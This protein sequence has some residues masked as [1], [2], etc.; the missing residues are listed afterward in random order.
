M[1]YNA[2]PK[3]TG[4]A[5]TVGYVVAANHFETDG[6][7]AHSSATRDVVNAKLTFAAESTRVTVIGSRSTSPNRRI[8][9]IDAA[10]VDADPRQADPV[11]VPSIRARP[12]INCRVGSQSSARLRTDFRV[13]GYG[14]NRQIG[15][16]RAVRR[17]T[18]SSGGGE[19]RL[20]LAVSAHAIS[21]AAIGRARRGSSP[22]APTPTDVS[23]GKASSTTTATRARA[24]R[25]RH[26]C[27]RRR[28]AQLEWNALPALSLTL[29]VR[30]SQVRYESVDHYIV[31]PN[32]DDSGT[33]T[34]YNTSPIAAAVWHAA[35]NL[36]VYVSY[37]QGF[38]TPTFAELAYR[39]VG[40]GLNL[41]LDPATSTSVEL[42]LKWLPSPR[43]RVN[44]AVFAAET[45]QEIVIDTATGGRTTYRNAGKTRR[46]GFEAV[47]DADL[48]S[49]FA[50]HANYSWLKAEFVDSFF[51]GLPP[52]EVPAGAHLPGVPPQQALASSPMHQE[53][54]TASARRPVQ[55]V[56]RVYV[57]DRNT[58]FAPA[59]T[60]ERAHRIR[61]DRGQCPVRRV[62][63]GQQHRRRELHRIGHRG[64]HQR[65]LLRARPW[66]QLVRRSECQ[67][68]LLSVTPAR[69]S[70][71]TG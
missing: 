37:G 48:G 50:V 27:Q 69:Q 15:Q 1:T 61:A 5:A 39:P 28:Y 14:G 58:A 24:R 8:L 16:Y 9:P 34:Y 46:R 25:R 6:Y 19:S 45:D 55:Y 35:S 49:G 64:R 26:G 68:R 38:E 57:N 62:R 71:C 20:Q 3:A 2:G 12:S 66:P 65:P 21:C 41:A 17:G 51:T 40:T 23:S 47:W 4:T 42:G 53:A 30:S 52:T 29:G 44:L 59:Y 31:P 33:R 13:T 56:G 67:C 63:A 43:Q 54:S 11:A 60:V 10:Q 18:T 22:S 70:C 32:P 7:R 36:N